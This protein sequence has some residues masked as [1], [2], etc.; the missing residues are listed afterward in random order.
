MED[1]EP[2]KKT[3]NT[4]DPGN[5]EISKVSEGGKG[6]KEPC[7]HVQG[8]KTLSSTLSHNPPVSSAF[9]ELTG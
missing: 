9:P 4:W 3:G 7:L 1:K 6:R 5:D 8:Y 2:E